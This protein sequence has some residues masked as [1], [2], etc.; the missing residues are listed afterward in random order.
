MDLVAPG[1]GLIIWQ[2]LGLIVAVIGI[3]FFSYLGYLGVKAL[4]KYTA[5]S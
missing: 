2:V 3:G 5:K 1:N 4:R